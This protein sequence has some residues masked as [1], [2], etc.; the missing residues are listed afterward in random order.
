MIH[1]YIAKLYQRG[2]HE[3]ARRA[4]A[5][6]ITRAHTAEDEPPTYEP[7]P[8][9]IDTAEAEY[10][11]A[12]RAHAYGPPEAQMEYV[13]EHGL[14]AWKTRVAQIKAEIPKPE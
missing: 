4:L 1:D 2:Q 14:T 13:T 3:Q 6:E 12:R 10:Y 8:A 5:S 9:E 7:I 11:A